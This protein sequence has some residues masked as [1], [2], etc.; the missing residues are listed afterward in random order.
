MPKK[1]WR[2]SA[3][4]VAVGIFA[5]LAIVFL[6]LG[7]IRARQNNTSLLAG[8]SVMAQTLAPN[9]ANTNNSSAINISS[10]TTGTTDNVD[11]T[12]NSNQTDI[13]EQ[14]AGGPGTCKLTSAADVLSVATPFNRPFSWLICRFGDF[15][16]GLINF[17]KNIDCETEAVSNN[18]IYGTN[19]KGSYDRNKGECVFNK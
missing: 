14:I 13:F 4:L 8:F 17:F 6:V 16:F 19:Y 11:S 7:I 12:K 1:S 9:T 5:L 3:V 2:D 15:Y 18:T 10:G